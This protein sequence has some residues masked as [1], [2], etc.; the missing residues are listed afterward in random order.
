[1]QFLRT[2]DDVFSNLPDFPFAPHYVPLADGLRMHHV[3]EGPRDGNPVLLLHGQPTW[4]YLY[5]KVVPVLVDHGYRVIAPDLIGFGRSDKP[6]H[7]T[8]H[9]VQSHITWLLELLDA[10]WL[11]D[12]TL[13]AQDWG[14]PFGLGILASSPERFSRV[15]ATNTVLHTADPSMA[16]QLN[17]ACH[18]MPDG[19]VS[20]AQNLLDYQRITQE[21]HRFQPGLFVQGATTTEL[22]QNVVAAYNAPFPDEG[23]CAG[24]RQLP[25]LMGLTQGSACARQN[26][27]TLKV[28]ETFDRPFLTA[29]SDGDPST[30]GWE[31]FFQEHIPGA[32]GQPH[33]VIGGAGHFVQEDKGDELAQVIQQFVVA[34]P[35]RLP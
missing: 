19:T 8:D 9:S 10:L 30:Q 6:A 16:G 31:R 23:F 11:T 26:K 18:A 34:N 32:A 1:M 15:V 24:P 13:V 21:I 17:W 3:D 5:R 35:N 7:R 28:L 2:P 14:G 22:T 12:I 33:V 20:I 27:R 4:S 29:F 25:L